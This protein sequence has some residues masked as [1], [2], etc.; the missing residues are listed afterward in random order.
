MAEAATDIGVYYINVVPTA[1]GFSKSLGDQLDKG[2]S[3]INGMFAKATAGGAKLMSKIGKAGLGAITTVAGGLVTL[4]AKGG[5]DRALNIE[6]AQVKLKALG[7]SAGDVKSVMGSALASVKG[8][9]FG[10]GDAASTAA[11]LIAGG[12]KKGDELTSVL[13]TVGDTAQVSGRSFSDIGLIFSQVAAKGKLKGDDMLQLMGSGIPVLKLLADHFKTTTDDAQDMVTKGKVSFADFAAAMKEGLGGAALSSGQSFDG[14]MANVKSALGRLGEKFETPAI[15]GLTKVFN[16][17][18]PVIDTFTGSVDG[19]AGKAG[20]KM[21]KWAEKA[22]QIINDFSKGL[23]NGSVNLQEIAVKAAT[24]AGALAF[25]A[26]GD[27]LAKLVTKVPGGADKAVAKTSSILAAFAGKVP[28]EASKAAEEASD[29]MTKAVEKV[30]EEAGKAIR[31]SGGVLED[32]AVKTGHAF[33]SIGESVKAQKQSFNSIFN[34]D[35]FGVKALERLPARLQGVGGKVIDAM[36]FVGGGDIEKSLKAMPGQLM[37]GVLDPWETVIN[38]S[39]QWLKTGVSKIGDTLGS[40]ISG[41]LNVTKV[42]LNPTA[43]LGAIGIGGIVAALIAALGAIDASMGGQITQQVSKF[44]TDLPNLIQQGVDYLTAQLPTWLVF[45]VN[46]IQTVIQGITDNAPALVNGATQIITSL[47]DGLALYLP[48]LVPMALNMVMAL[49]GGLLSNLPQM[50]TSGLNL[51]LGL[52]TGLMN[53]LPQLIAQVPVIFGNFLNNLMANL[54]QMISTGFTLITTLGVGLIK[55]IPSIVGAMAGIV[56]A[57]FN[58]LT[59]TDW[60][61]VG[62]NIISG[63]INGVKAMGGAFLDAIKKI[64]SSALDA[65]KSFFGIHSPS[66]VMRDQVGRFLPL[67]MAAGIEDESDSVVDA[68]GS[69]MRIPREQA[70]KYGGLLGSVGSGGVDTRLIQQFNGFSKDSSDSAGLALVAGKL[71]SLAT[72]LADQTAADR[73]FTMRD[74][75]R[76]TRSVG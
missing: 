66:R 32:F 23:Q 40:S 37:K 51:L 5:F 12:I 33:A 21:N 72:I 56:G 42:F 69:M 3:N 8:T 57:I 44:F 53:A 26:N 70:L 14:A 43:I 16:A 17:L 1:K 60:I 73:P 28:E 2:T 31:K 48:A 41:L 59:H 11:T 71:D 63:L 20:E 54:P 35:A 36:K 55:A 29:G 74:F 67:G 49:V 50:V 62:R 22:V 76:L 61:S 58:A 46:I 34:D 19:L 25:L 10:M 18:I 75:A 7:Y 9:A 4:A 65:V 27:V 13:K 52:V 15:T 6:R 39:P 45:G 38:E 68:M 24:A 47:V 30:P 64:C